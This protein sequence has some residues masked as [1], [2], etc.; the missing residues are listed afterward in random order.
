MEPYWAAISPEACVPAIPKAWTVCSF[1][2]RKADAAADADENTPT[3]DAECQPWA[4]CSAPMQIPTRGPVSYPATAAVRKSRLDFG[5]REKSR[6]YYG[7]HVNR[8]HAVD[9]V[10]LEPLHQ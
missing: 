1:E 9:I 6:Q 7:P 3:V 10:E 4:R 8:A 5:D 2:S